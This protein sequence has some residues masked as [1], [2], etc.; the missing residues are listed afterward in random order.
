MC[1]EY[2]EDIELPWEDID[3][4]NAENAGSRASNPF[5]ILETYLENSV[6]TFGLV[7]VTYMQGK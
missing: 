1:P 5:T 3:V 6:E 2:K 4:S 7:Q